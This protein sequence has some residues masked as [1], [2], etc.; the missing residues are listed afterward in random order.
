MVQ[1]SAAADRIRE[2]ISLISDIAGQANLLALNATIESARTGEAGRSFAV[3]AA[4]VKVLAGQTGKAT[5]EIGQQIVAMQ[6][7]SRQ[8]VAAIAENARHDQ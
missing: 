7:I 5:E 4:E 8:S 1:L 6:E 2:V 3:V